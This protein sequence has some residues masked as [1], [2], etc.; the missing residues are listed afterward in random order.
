MRHANNLKDINLEFCIEYL[1]NCGLE[2]KRSGCPVLL[3]DFI[4]VINKLISIENNIERIKSKSPILIKPKSLKQNKKKS[5]NHLPDFNFIWEQLEL[6]Q[7]ELGEQVSETQVGWIVKRVETIFDELEILEKR[8]TLILLILQG[9]SK[10]TNKERI[11]LY[12]HIEDLFPFLNELIHFLRN[13]HAVE[14]VSIIEPFEKEKHLPKPKN[15]AK[16]SVQVFNTYSTGSRLPLVLQSFG[17]SADRSRFR[18][19]DR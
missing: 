18:R 16:S 10:W 4:S 1:M 15:V 7:Q 3:Q 12:R 14:F 8:I 11:V 6:V 13:R 9:D 5:Y 19:K 17:R 2:L